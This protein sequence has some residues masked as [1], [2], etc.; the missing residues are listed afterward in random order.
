MEIKTLGE[1]FDMS[2]KILKNMLEVSFDSGWMNKS[3]EREFSSPLD[4]NC[5][6][7]LWNI[8]PVAATKVNLCV[9]IR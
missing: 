2:D 6:E 3:D 4:V 9:Y 8:M 1:I 5:F 7:K